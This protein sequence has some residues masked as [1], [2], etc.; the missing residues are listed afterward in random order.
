MGNLGSSRGGGLV[1]VSLGILS[2]PTRTPRRTRPPRPTS[3]SAEVVAVADDDADRGRAFAAEHGLDYGDAREVLDRIDAAVACAVNT[4]HGDW[5]RRA[6]TAGVD[7]LCEKPLAP[8]ADE[9]HDLVR[10]CDGARV[11]LGVAM[12]VRFNDPVRRAKARVDAGEIGDVQAIVRT[13]LLQ[14]MAADTWFS[15][16]ELSGGGAI[17]DHSVHVVDLARWFTGREVTEVYTETVTKFGDLSVEDVDILSME[18]SDGTLFTHDGSWR[19]PEEWD[20][21]GDVTLRLIGTEG[22]LD[23]DCFDQTFTETRD[24]GSNP[25]TESVFWGTNMDEGLIRD[26]V[27]SVDEGRE[28]AVPGDE[29]VREVRV[30]EAAYR[31]AKDGMPVEVTY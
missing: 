24:A 30:V 22:V 4:D 19:Q 28:P 16:P 14:K 10:V 25:G 29:G 7:V 2:A 20:F 8:T 23:I 6:A 27:D 11:A 17:M 3:R 31:S 1:T 26:F 21:W 9:A 5:V 12:P 13:N 18:L 15:D